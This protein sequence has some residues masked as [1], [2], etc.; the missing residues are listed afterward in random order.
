VV[1]VDDPWLQLLTDSASDIVTPASMR[2]AA[3]H[4]YETLNSFH[5]LVVKV[6]GDLLCL[7]PSLTL[8]AQTA[9][10]MDAFTPEM[11][12]ALISKASHNRNVSRDQIML[13]CLGLW[14]ILPQTT[15][16]T[17]FFLAPPPFARR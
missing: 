16:T 14:V 12:E 3:I 4:M 11:L 17:L 2:Q 1:P 15:N 6:Q 5:Q 13:V 9:C 7:L 8:S 10:S